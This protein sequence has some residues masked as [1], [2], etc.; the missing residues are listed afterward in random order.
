MDKTRLKNYVGGFEEHLAEAAAS[1]SQKTRE[2]TPE[3]KPA[4][5]SVRKKKGTSSKGKTPKK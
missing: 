2:K 5:K 1:S 4:G 3:K